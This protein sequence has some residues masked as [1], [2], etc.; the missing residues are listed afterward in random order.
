MGRTC[1]CSIGGVDG[2]PFALAPKEPSNS[3]NAKFFGSAN[4]PAGPGACITLTTQQRGHGR[5]VEAGLFVDNNL[6]QPP[7]HFSKQTNNSNIRQK[8]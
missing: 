4:T 1:A 2:V 6:Q 8:V 7:A 3:S 5:D